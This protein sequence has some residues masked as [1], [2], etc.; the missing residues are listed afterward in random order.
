MIE[1]LTIPSN[2][3]VN[4]LRVNKST[5]FT[6]SELKLMLRR[7]ERLKDKALLVLLYETA[8]R[9]AEIRNL[10][11]SDINWA[12]QEV[13]LY[14]HKTGE[15]RDLPIQEALKH[16]KRWKEEWIF[17]DPKKTTIV[18]PSTFGKGYDREKHLSVGYIT[19]IIKRLARQAY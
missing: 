9:P 3:L 2:Y 14:S 15:D 12:E 7:A 6:E 5:L 4:K 16:L 19:R 10:K 11:W 17:P 8:A 13:H 18:F 1:P